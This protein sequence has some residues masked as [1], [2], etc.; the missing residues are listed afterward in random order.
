MKLIGLGL[1]TFLLAGLLIFLGQSGAFSNAQDRARGDNQQQFSDPQRMSVQGIELTG[2][3]V[4]GAALDTKTPLILSGLPSYTGQRFHLPTDA[5]PV[6]GQYILSFSSRIAE[7]LEGVLRVTINGTKRADIL[8]SDDKSLG[9]NKKRKV[10]VELMASE[11]VSGVLD[12]GLSLQGRGPIAKCTPDDAIAAVV[13]IDPESGLQLTLSKPVET[14]VDKLALWGGRVP[15]AW[16]PGQS[17][18]DKSVSIIYASRLVQ[19]GYS[20]YFTHNGINNEQLAKLTN[21]ASLYSNLTIPTT[22]PIPLTSDS[23]NQGVRR[24]DRQTSWRYRYSADALPGKLLPAALELRMALGPTGG[25]SQYNLVV[26]LN[27]HMLLA[28]R[29]A[30]QVER[31]N[32]SIVLPPALQKTQNNLEITLVD[33]SRDELRCGST[34][35][36]VAELLPET[37]LR[38]GGAP[39]KDGLFE[40]KSLLLSGGDATFSGM[41]TTPVDASA[42]TELLAA[43]DP[44]R[45]TFGKKDGPIVMRLVTGDIAKQSKSSDW[46]VYHSA[47]PFESYVAKR[48]KEIGNLSAIPIALVISIS[49]KQFSGLSPATRN[50]P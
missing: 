37:V 18:S 7:G 38:S 35:Q 33:T 23:A 41:S 31:I 45:L 17:A 16:L 47:E 24:F 34:S 8:L 26:T 20:P 30:P 10:S 1:L 42:A 11:L 13:E 49:G 15:V 36:S 9:L 39:A 32:Q 50:T 28:Q 6:S 40:L 48:R 14:S 2:K 21:E 22:Y 4:F 27:E 46:I 5:R 25:N 12:I 29:I 19:K 44:Q 43:L 3:E